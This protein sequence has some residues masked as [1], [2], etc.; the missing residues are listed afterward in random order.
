MSIRLGV[1]I[2]HVATLRNARGGTYPD[3]LRAAHMCKTAGADSLTIHLR[4]DRRHIRDADV[5][6]LIE[7]NTLPINLEMAA[8][9]EMVDIALRLKPY[10]VCIVPEKRQELTTE[11]GLDVTTQFSYLTQIM[12]KLN[13]VQI[14]T[15]LFV[16]ADST[17]IKMA[18][19][20]GA[21]CIEIHTGS[22]AEHF[23]N[24][25]AQLKAIREAARQAHEL[26]M[27]VH[28]GH[29]LNYD[30]VREVARVAH[31]EELNIGHFL[32]GEAIFTGLE[33]SITCMKQL[34]EGAS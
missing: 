5:D 22:Y 19:E 30:N 10:A 28:A 21:R 4:E 17:Q 16:D 23:P 18:K 8:T 29:G 20:T 24:A 25:Q 9:A 2:D 13:Q 26:G 34:I 15:A 11:G 1:N 6:A 7:A 3:I 14:R 12:Q 32:I 31:M 33:H 27:E